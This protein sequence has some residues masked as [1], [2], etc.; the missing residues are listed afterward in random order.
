[1]SL[2]PSGNAPH[3]VSS[4]ATP[5]AAFLAT[6][7]VLGSAPSAVLGRQS[8]RQL[9]GVVV[10]VACLL[11]AL[12]V[13]AQ[14]AGATS[15]SEGGSK[16]PS[17][18]TMVDQARALEQRIQ[19]IMDEAEAMKTAIAESK[20]LQASQ[21]SSTAMPLLSSAKRLADGHVAAIRTAEAS[22]D[23]ETVNTELQQLTV[24]HERMATTLGELKQ[25]AS[26]GGSSPDSSVQLE[27]QKG[28]SPNVEPEK[29]LQD[30]SAQSADTPSASPFFNDKETP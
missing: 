28:D 25:C 24:M 26:G 4:S 10:G 1:M 23:R 29:T 22:G 21:C 3:A 8:L 9:V 15:G 5:K 19:R 2:I 27:T 6:S 17:M 14:E 7:S 11:I 30:L 18:Q 12:R 16:A 13:T 20:D